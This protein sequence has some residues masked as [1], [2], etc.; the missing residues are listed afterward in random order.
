MGRAVARPATVL[1]YSLG[2]KFVGGYFRSDPVRRRRRRTGTSSQSNLLRYGLRAP[3]AHPQPQLQPTLLLQ[4]SA[5]YSTHGICVQRRPAPATRATHTLLQYCTE[6]Y[7]ITHTTTRKMLGR[8]LTEQWLLR[9]RSSTP[10]TVGVATRE[11]AY[12]LH[13]RLPTCYT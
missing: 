4:L 5:I 13:V 3:L 10:S 2:E 11:A 7:Y 6:V 8:P 1:V 12:M 9:G